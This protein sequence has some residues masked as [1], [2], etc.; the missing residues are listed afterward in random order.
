L[1]SVFEYICSRFVQLCIVGDFNLPHFTNEL[2]S[3]NWV[4][5]KNN[6][7]GNVITQYGLKQLVHIPTRFDNVLDLLFCSKHTMCSDVSITNPF[8]SSD[9]SSLLF[10]IFIENEM[11]DGAPLKYRDF[12]SGDY[13]AFGTFLNGIDWHSLLLSTDSVNNA[14][15]KFLE[16]MLT[17]INNFIPFKIHKQCKN[18]KKPSYPVYILKLQL[19]KKLLWRNRSHADGMAAY[20]QAADKCRKAIHDYHMRRESNLLSIDQKTFIHL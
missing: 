1:S 15:D 14:W 17:G 12:K 7:L 11:P 19:K 5:T 9:H 20:R 16:V 4:T 6:K 10:K 18:S 8:S 2:S 13:R 3:G